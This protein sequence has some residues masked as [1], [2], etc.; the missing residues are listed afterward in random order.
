MAALSVCHSLSAAPLA[1]VPPSPFSSLLQVI[2][3]L[4]V[5][6]AAIVGLA[7]LFRRFSGGMLGASN[8]LRLVSGA[9]VGPKE[10]VVIVE[11]EG[12][13]LVLGVTASQVNLLTKIPRP[14]DADQLPV[15]L[16]TPFA[17]RLKAALDKSRLPGGQVEK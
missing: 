15:P 12:E 3:G 11:L 14:A 4:A 16:D 5:V 1:A 6:L 9:M 7:W 2:M 17:A 13:W 10:R 8:R